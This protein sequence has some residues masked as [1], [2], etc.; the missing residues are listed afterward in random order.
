MMRFLPIALFAILVIF[1]F[2]GLSI[3]PKKIPSSF[4]DK[5]IPEFTL[6]ILSDSH[7]L[8]SN[9]TLAG[10]PYLLNVF[11]STCEPC[12]TEHGLLLHIAQEKNIAIYGLNYKDTPKAALQ[13][14][15][16][17]GN[18]YQQVFLDETG[19]TAFNLG[20][21]GTPETFLIDGKGII[22]YRW[23]GPLNETVWK[24]K[25]LPLIKKT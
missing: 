21:Y 20:V 14:L 12:Q 10:K 11:A 5:P 3:D 4:I 23:T 18:P 8:R 17:L 22:R 6:P 25:F 19:H 7:T 9:K 13:F 24:E 15:Q 1:F 16:E 2:Y